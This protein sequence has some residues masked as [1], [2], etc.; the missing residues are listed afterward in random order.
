MKV[1]M[2]PGMKQHLKSTAW[3]IDRSRDA[4]GK[5]SSAAKSQFRRPPRKFRVPHPVR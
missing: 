5:P 2:K 3:A 4:G 1:T